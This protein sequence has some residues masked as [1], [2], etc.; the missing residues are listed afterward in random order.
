M[1]RLVQFIFSTGGAV[2]F[3]FVAALGVALRPRSSAVRR[4]LVVCA[5]FYLAAS[6]YLVP[7]AISKI[8]ISR[9]H[10]FEQADVPRGKLALVV[11]GSG[12]EAVGGWEDRIS[13]PND[14]AAARVLETARV[15]RIAHPAWVISS[16]GNPDPDDPAEPSSTNMRDMLVRLGVPADRILLESLSRNSHDEAVLIAPMLRSLGVDA[17]VLVTSAVH[18]PRSVGA[19][20]AVGWTPTPAVA[21]DS[22][23]ENEWIDWVHPTTH[24]LD[25]SEQVAHELIG[26]PYY[27]LRGWW[28]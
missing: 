12:D 18:M 13:I 8:L 7:V 22:W 3:L 17:L 4:F 28:R 9:Y 25:F 16:G 24:G 2:T 6:I 14:T 10:R 26:L 20:R 27:R 15:Y 11:F 19:F 21:P 23:F 1:S 5:A